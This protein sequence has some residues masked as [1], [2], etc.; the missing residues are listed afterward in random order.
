MYVGIIK[1]TVVLIFAAFTASIT[2]PAHGAQQL[3]NNKLLLPLLSASSVGLI[4]SESD[5]LFMLENRIGKKT[6]F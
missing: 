6:F 5:S 2:S 1:I 3:C 4:Y